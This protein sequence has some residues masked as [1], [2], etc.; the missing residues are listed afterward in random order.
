MILN[1]V[2]CHFFSTDFFAALG[3]ALPDADMGDPADRAITRLRWEAPGPPERLADRWIAELDRHA[4]RRSALIAS[5][6]G[7]AHS[8]AAALARHPRRFV[9]FF[10]VDPT[11]P[12]AEVEAAEAIDRYTLRVICLFPAMHRYPL[13]DER[14]RR[15]FDVAAARPGTAIFVHCGVLSVGVR[16]KLELPSPF[17]IRFGNPLDLHPLALSYPS[18]PILIPHFGAG[19]FRE[20]LMIADLCPNVLLDTS[21]SNAWMKYES[22]RL[23]LADVFK[24]AL[25]VVG[26][27]RLL[28]GSDSSFFPRGWVKDVF[29]RQRAALQEIGVDRDVMDKIFGGNFDRVFPIAGSRGKP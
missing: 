21:S 18:V 10:M 2:H 24:R 28:F 16:K 22:A 11:Q 20:A 17:D 9:G 14:V 23:T 12:R 13:S 8:V 7:D 19:L 25:D 5:V 4:I 27:D 1:D 6:P 3:R 26:P 15:L 29:E